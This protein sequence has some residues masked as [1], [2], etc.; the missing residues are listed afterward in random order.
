VDWPSVI[1]KVGA[2]AAGVIAALGGV[3]AA[4]ARKTK[5]PPLPRR[6]PPPVP[7]DPCP[8]KLVEV[9]AEIA[10]LWGAVGDL[11][12]E[13]RLVKAELAVARHDRQSVPGSRRG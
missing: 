4:R 3:A 6:L 1:E 2:A 13:L 9:D 10:R 8:E 7:S 11:R 12:E 5:L